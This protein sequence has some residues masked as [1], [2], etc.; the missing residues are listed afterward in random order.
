MANDTHP[1]LSTGASELGA[2]LA[3]L[4]VPEQPIS[5]QVVGGE[6]VP[7]S[8]VA[9][10][11]GPAA[12]AWLVVGVLALATDGGPVSAGVWHQIQRPELIQ[13]EHDGRV[14]N[15][16]R[17]LA[18]GDR[19]EMVGMADADQDRAFLEKP[20]DDLGVAGQ[21]AA[22]HLAGVLVAVLVATGEHAPH[23]ALAQ[24]ITQL[25]ATAQW[26]FDHVVLASDRFR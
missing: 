23:G 4:D 6:Q 3:G 7:D 22:Q 25:V 2:F 13:A 19:V 11:G 24:R 1:A 20:R 21:I 5:G 14:V 9:I 15:V 18:V 17:H 26:L 10:V 12:G 16:G 8:V